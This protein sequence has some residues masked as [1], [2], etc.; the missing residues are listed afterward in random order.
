M[1]EKIVELEEYKNLLENKNGLDNETKNVD[2]LSYTCMQMSSSYEIPQDIIS[3]TA[4][5]VHS[6]TMS[7][8]VPSDVS[9][10]GSAFCDTDIR[11][12][13]LLVDN[14]DIQITFGDFVSAQYGNFKGF[15]FLQLHQYLILCLIM[16][17]FLL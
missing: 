2:D 7:L 8:D 13:N 10:I 17:N 12:T 9:S 1:N 15:Q 5:T 16:L 14:T 11:D 4:L 6:Y 3:A